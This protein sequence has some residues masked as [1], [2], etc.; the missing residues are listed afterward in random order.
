MREAAARG[1]SI[2]ITEFERRLR[3]PQ[4]D[5]A[6]GPDP[7]EELERMLYGDEA[8][9]PADPDD[10]VFA[11]WAPHRPSTPPAPILRPAKSPYREDDAC[12][13]ELRGS[14]DDTPSAAA[15]TGLHDRREVGDDDQNA[16]WPPDESRAYLDFGEDE[17][18][19]AAQSDRDIG[20][21]LPKVWLWA[22]AAGVAALGVASFGW[23]FAHPGGGGATLEKI[24]SIVTPNGRAKM[25][26]PEQG[27]A[28]PNHNESAPARKVA[29]SEERSVDLPV[30]PNILP[31]DAGQVDAPH[32]PG[33]SS[34]LTPRKVKTVSVQPDAGVADN[35]SAPA[36]PSGREAALLVNGGEAN[37]AAN[38]ARTV[39]PESPAAPAR[40]AQPSRRKAEKVVSA[41][42][43]DAPADIAASGDGETFEVRLGSAGT[44]TEARRLMGQIASKFGSQ[45]GGRA[46]GYR[47]AKVDEKT[48][49]L[50]RLRRDLG[51]ESAVDICEKIKSTGGNCIVA[52]K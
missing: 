20:R 42:E 41:P 26:R 48:V 18:R 29:T 24:A 11:E 27:A 23:T 51:R 2:D 19:R 47:H 6:S 30:A 21:R 40:A 35:D 9:A 3:A 31:V 33:D 5:E 32:Q 52:A 4:P 38:S 25:T 1:P 28:V 39:T 15:R 37:A 46:L 49:Y 16:D 22:A 17:Q 44:Q 14:L 45:F 10:E 34:V 36:F 50:V 43:T 12:D 8:A 7:F 13:G